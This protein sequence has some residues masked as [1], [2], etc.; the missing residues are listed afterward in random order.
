[1]KHLILICM[2]SLALIACDN[3]NSQKVSASGSGSGSGAG[4]LAAHA[5][6][7][8]ADECPTDIIG[9]Y[10]T[11]GNAGDLTEILLIGDVLTVRDSEVGDLPVDGSIHTDKTD[12]SSNSIIC[13]GGKLELVSVD[14]NGETW[15][16][17]VSKSGQ[18]LKVINKANG[19]TVTLV[20]Q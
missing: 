12:G 19:E 3:D 6:A 18:D 1:M 9:T 7:H 4:D 20:R 14:A 17:S 13:Q 15:E 16:I 5:A 8:K 10:A 2:A 11:E